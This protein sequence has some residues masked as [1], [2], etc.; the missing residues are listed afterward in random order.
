MAKK[1]P[2]LGIHIDLLKPQSNPE[3]IAVKLIR[4]LLS[5]GRYIFII[6]EAVVLLAFIARFKLDADISAKKEAIENQLPYIRSLT[7]YETL[8]KQLQTKLAKIGELK[9]SSPNYSDILQKIAD[10]I[11]TGLKINSMSIQSKDTGVEINLAGESQNNTDLTIFVL[12]L[13]QTTIFNNINYTSIGY[14]D[15]VINFS[16]TFS[17]IQAKGES[18]SL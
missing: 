15:G 9:T 1:S 6:V 4:W 13:K 2:K 17:R 12:G 7:P 16:L 3:K 10:Q 14:E 11:P 8:I 18:K 5:T